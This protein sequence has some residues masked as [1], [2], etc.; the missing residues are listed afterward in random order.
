M[1]STLQQKAQD[2][3]RAN[4]AAIGIHSELSK[5]GIPELDI[6]EVAVHEQLQGVLV[7][8][9]V[10]ISEAFGLPLPHCDQV[11]KIAGDDGWS[12]SGTDGGQSWK[13]QSSLQMA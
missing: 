13:S 10:A 1:F 12:T 7:T 2:R 8:Q 11:D 5:K 3:M 6:I 9:H 4:Q